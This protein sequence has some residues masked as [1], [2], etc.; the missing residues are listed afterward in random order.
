LFVLACFA[1]A[2]HASSV[3]IHDA[4]SNWDTRLY[5][6]LGTQ[7]YTEPYL[8]AFFPLFPLV[9]RLLVSH[10]HL[11]F[12]WVA[13]TLN[14]ALFFASLL[15]VRRL[16]APILG[17][18][19]ALATSALLAVHPLSFYFFVPYTESLFLFLTLS[20]FLA[21]LRGRWLVAALAG[22]LAVL[23]RNTGI[24]LWPALWVLAGDSPERL[25]V[26]AR[27]ATCVLP[28]ALLGLMTYTRIRYGDALLF[29]HGQRAWHDHIHLAVPFARLFKDLG[30]W[31]A[32]V[33]HHLWL[34]LVG[35]TGVA[36]VLRR[37]PRAFAVYA[38]PAVLLSLS[39]SKLAITPRLH[40]VL[41]PLWL[42]WGVFLARG[43]RRALAWALLVLVSAAMEAR[44]IGEYS[45]GIWVE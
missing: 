13:V 28:A 33:D 22:S 11:D 18:G 15:L 9:A 41:F 10:L 19:A 8:F 45:R 3:S 26:R 1:F 4:V 39:L 14:N 43:R 12:V 20:T 5:E 23:T 27:V 24:L 35:L 34:T 44:L 31:R 2:A 40:V 38:V 21:A 42:A 37:L 36:L 29:L 30:R 17:S 6:H 32:W 25:R 16:A 7:G